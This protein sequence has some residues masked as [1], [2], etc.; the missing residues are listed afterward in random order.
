MEKNEDFRI[1]KEIITI[2]KKE[3]CTVSDAK[4]ILRNVG[5]KLEEAP[6]QEPQKA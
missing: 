1:E 4:F 2:L 5:V 6:V 3:K